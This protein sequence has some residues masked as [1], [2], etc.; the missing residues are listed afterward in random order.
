MN[1]LRSHSD[2]PGKLTGCQVERQ[3]PVAQVAAK[4]APDGRL[5][6]AG[7]LALGWKWHGQQ[8]NRPWE[9]KLLLGY[10]ALLGAFG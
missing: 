2:H 6:L 1:P 4:R 5:A 7:V 3:P 10:A 9:E 8:S